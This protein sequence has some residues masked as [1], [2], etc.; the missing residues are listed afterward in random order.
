MKLSNSLHRGVIKLSAGR[1]G[2]DA[3]GM[4]VIKLTTT[5]RKTGLPRSVMLTSPHQIGESLVLVASKGGSDTHP[6][7][8]LNLV[9]NPNVIV[10]TRIGSKEMTAQV[11]D[12]D[13]REQL[14]DEVTEK[15]SNYGQYQSKTDRLIPLIVLS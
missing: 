15:F 7:W 4:P 13:V 14:W 6:E 12:A 3:F 11:V 1:K 9:A 5:G 8:F 2:W 10:E